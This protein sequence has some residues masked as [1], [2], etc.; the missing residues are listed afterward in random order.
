[1]AVTHGKIEG[2]ITI[3]T[4]GWDFELDDATGGPYT[5]SL[6]AA[7][8]YYHS[9]AGNDTVTLA[10]RLKALMDTAS[11]GNVYTVSVDATEDG[12]GLYT[13]SVDSG[14]FDVTWTDTD[15]GLLLGIN[16]FVGQSSITG[17]AQ[18]LGLWLPDC[19]VEAPFG[20]DSAGWTEYDMVATQAPDGTVVTTAHNTRIA[21]SLTWAACTAGKVRTDDESPANESWQTFFDDCIYAETSW[22]GGPILFYPDAGSATYTEYKLVAPITRQL[23]ERVVQNYTGLYRIV[24]E[25]LVKVP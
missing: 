8:T 19:P 2:R 7:K 14:T 20:K 3:P 12:T 16:D 13:I 11:T 6:T 15:L 5:V 1:M 25:R 10:A 9:T 22:G 23:P 24:L 17:T 18:C 21:N 4:G